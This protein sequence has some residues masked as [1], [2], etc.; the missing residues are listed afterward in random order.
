M[1]SITMED[2]EPYVTSTWTIMMLRVIF[3]ICIKLC[4]R[5]L[6]SQV[7]QLYKAFQN[8]IYEGRDE[9]TIIRLKSV[10]TT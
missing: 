9:V 6:D 3:R 8:N 2:E 4:V 1:K 10:M 7:E 5:C